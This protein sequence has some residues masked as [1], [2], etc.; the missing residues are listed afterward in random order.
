MKLNICFKLL[1]RVIMG[2]LFSI[3]DCVETIRMETNSIEPLP[4][5]KRLICIEGTS[6]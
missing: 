3:K 6:C 1:T 4:H 5:R 2:Q